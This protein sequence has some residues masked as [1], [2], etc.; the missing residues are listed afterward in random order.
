MAAPVNIQT[1]ARRGFIDA[2]C[3]TRRVTWIPARSEGVLAL[4]ERCW[5]PSS[6]SEPEKT[7]CFASWPVFAEPSVAEIDSMR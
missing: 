2:Y 3:K 5:M 6:N 7:I 4:S 1:L